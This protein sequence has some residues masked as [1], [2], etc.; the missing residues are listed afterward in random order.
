MSHRR[1]G[2]VSRV[3][4]RGQSERGGAH[5]ARPGAERVASGGGVAASRPPRAGY[6]HRLL[7]RASSLVIILAPLVSFDLLS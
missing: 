6:R 3:W 4:G 5:V 7:Q 2:V 1:V